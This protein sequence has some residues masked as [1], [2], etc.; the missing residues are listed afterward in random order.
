MEIEAERK[1]TFLESISG[2]ALMIVVWLFVVTF[3]VQNFEIPSSSMEKT[4]LIG[5]HVLVD[6]STYQ[7]HHSWM[8]LIYNRPVQHGDIIVFFKP[9]PEQPDFIL[10][11][12]AI[13]LPGDRIHLQDG[14]VYRNGVALHEPQISMPDAD[15]PMDPYRDQFPSI[16]PG[17]GEVTALWATEMPGH[18]QN[19]DLVV[20]PGKIFAMG[21]NR[22][23]SLDSRYWGFVPM[24]NVLGRPLFV[25][26]SFQ[27]PA[28]QINKTSANDRISFF[29]HIITHFVS[30][31]RWSRTFHR[32][33]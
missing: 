31:T 20:P 15:H 33:Q 27:T 2:T 30:D 9:N 13:G 8:P 1:E 12:R 26:W 18:I 11:K 24:E 5:D 14:V 10:V 17:D 16:P 28:D 32:M 19:G 6:H 4:M 25:Y 7:M 23:A 21:D 29:V 22:I 3:V